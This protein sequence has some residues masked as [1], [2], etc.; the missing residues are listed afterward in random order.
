LG[1]LDILLAQ[2]LLAQGFIILATQEAFVFYL[3][4]KAA[5][6]RVFLWR[7][8]ALPQKNPLISPAF[9]PKF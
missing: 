6:L 5:F 7:G 8:S 3:A 1:G 4:A 9:R 2:Q